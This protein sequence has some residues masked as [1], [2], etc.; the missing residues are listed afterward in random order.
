MDVVP[1]GLWPRIDVL[2]SEESFFPDVS[3][4]HSVELAVPLV[5]LKLTRVK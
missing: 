4:W 2:H 5:C 3:S 1:D